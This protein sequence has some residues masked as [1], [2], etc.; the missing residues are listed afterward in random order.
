MQQF[1]GRTKKQNPPTGQQIFVYRLRTEI[2]RIRKWDTNHVIGISERQRER[3]GKRES[4]Q[5]TGTFR[6]IYQVS[7][8]CVPECSS[9]VPR[10]IKKTQRKK[11]A[12]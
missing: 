3:E 11:R 4:E 9:A 2:F 8:T 10:Q 6:S 7:I 5:K 1:G 12:E